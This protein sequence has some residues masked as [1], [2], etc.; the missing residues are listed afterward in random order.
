MVAFTD[1]ELGLSQLTNVDQLLSN[2]II[3]HQV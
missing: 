2:S 3:I 1:V